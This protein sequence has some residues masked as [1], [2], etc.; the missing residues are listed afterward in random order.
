MLCVGR[1][2]EMS[3]TGWERTVG[4]IDGMGGFTEEV[5]LELSLKA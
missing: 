3:L 5:A 1:K 2:E 4:V